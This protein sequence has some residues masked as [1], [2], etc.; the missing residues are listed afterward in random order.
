MWGRMNA[1]A[2][3]RALLG[4]TPDEVNDLTN[5]ILAAE[6]RQLAAVQAKIETVMKLT[7]G[8]IWRELRSAGHL[9]AALDALFDLLHSQAPTDPAIWS[10]IP[11]IKDTGQATSDLFARDGHTGHVSHPILRALALFPRRQ[12]WKRANPGRLQLGL[13]AVMP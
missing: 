6:G 13:S 5:A 9:P 7:S 10:E 4:L 11:E 1:L 2:H 12:L 3:L 8:D